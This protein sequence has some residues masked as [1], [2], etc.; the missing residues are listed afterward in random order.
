[1]CRIALVSNRS[2]LPDPTFDLLISKIYSTRYEYN[3]HQ[4]IVS[5]ELYK[6]RS[7]TNLVQSINNGIKIQTQ[8]HLQRT[9]I[10]NQQDEQNDSS[11]SSTTKTGVDNFTRTVVQTN[12]AQKPKTIIVSEKDCS[13]ST[14]VDKSD[15]SEQDDPTRVTTSDELVELVLRPHPTKM[16]SDNSL[17]RH[18]NG[19]AVRYIKTTANATGEYINFI[20]IINSLIW[21]FIKN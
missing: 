19:H 17:L 13:V 7:Q 2:L 8:N 4:D 10:K 20:Y 16:D 3:L 11:C 18:L 12:I 5:E 21:V 14:P 6:S 1:M 15:V 9:N